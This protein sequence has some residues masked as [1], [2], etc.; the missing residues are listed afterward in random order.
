M[1]KVRL[2]QAR[3]LREALQAV[4]GKSPAILERPQESRRRS[5]WRPPSGFCWR[6]TEEEIILLRFTHILQNF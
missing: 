6:K 3:R 2:R 4:Q 1:Q 5:R